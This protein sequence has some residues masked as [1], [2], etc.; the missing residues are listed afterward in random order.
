MV[1]NGKVSEW[2]EVVSSVVQGC[3]L[4]PCVFVIFINGIDIAVDALSFIK[5]AVDSKAGRVVDST[6]DRQAFQDMLDKLE[7][8]SQEC[9]WQ[10]CC[11]ERHL[12]HTTSEQ[13]GGR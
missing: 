12:V 10:G 4:G 13:G 1:L 5:F 7:T 2:G 11:R 8:R 9:E 6:E 3:C